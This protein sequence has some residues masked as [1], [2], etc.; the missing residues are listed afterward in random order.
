MD[1]KLKRLL[2]HAL[3]C[4]RQSQQGPTDSGFTL[5]EL[6]IVV[7]IGGLIVS[8]LMGLVVE[9][10]ATEQRES[11]RTET[12]REMQLA[13]DY[14]TSDLRQ[15]V[16]VY[17]GKPQR[18]VAGVS[19]TDSYQDYLPNEYQECSDQTGLSLLEAESRFDPEAEGIPGYKAAGCDGLANDAL[20]KECNN[21]WLQRRTYTLV[22]YLKVP[23]DPNDGRWKGRSRIVRYELNKYENPKTFKRNKGY[24]DPGELGTGGFVNWPLNADGLNCQT[25]AC[26]RPTAPPGAPENGAEL[27]TLVDF[28]DVSDRPLPNGQPTPQCQGYNAAQPENSDYLMQPRN[29]TANA[30]AFYTCMAMPMQREPLKTFRFI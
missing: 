27:V 30:P 29:T 3:Q 6:L 7:I 1:N 22:A 8:T 13:M 4:R 12:E 15:A 23:N 18:I 24:V 9:L 21:L 11:A 19:E 26:G 20:Q 16:Y 25:N 10:V 5:T 17:D 28:V 2:L 14:I